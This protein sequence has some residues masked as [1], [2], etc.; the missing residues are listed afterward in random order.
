MD[1]SKALK[2]WKI[3]YI[4]IDLIVLLLLIFLS[5]MA[6]NHFGFYDSKEAQKENTLLIRM[7]DQPNKKSYGNEMRIKQIC[8]NGEPLN[9]QEYD[10][11]GWEWHENWGYTLFQEGDNEFSVSFSEIIKTMEVIYIR[12][13]GS[14][15][16]QFYWN[17]ELKQTVDMYSGKWSQGTFSVRYIS[18][19]DKFF[20]IISCWIVVSFILYELLRAFLFIKGTIPVEPINRGIGIYDFAKGVGIIFVVIGHT[21]QD[22]IYGREFAFYDPL[23]AII[24]LVDIYYILPMFYFIGGLNIKAS[25]NR[26]VIRKQLKTLLIPYGIYASMILTVNLVKLIFMD[27]FSISDYISY[28]MGLLLL[29]GHRKN[30]AGHFIMSIGPIWFIV[31]FCLGH[32]LVNYIINISNK[33]IRR[34]LM[35]IVVVTAY[36]LTKTDVAVLCVAE[37]FVAAI[38]LYIGHIYGKRIHNKLETGLTRSVYIFGLFASTLLVAFNGISFTLS[39]NNLGASFML[40][41]I[42][43]TLGGIAFLRELLD[44]GRCLGAKATVI[45]RIGR[46]SFFILFVHSFE[47]MIIPWNKF[48]QILPDYIYLRIFIVLVLRGVIIL[49]LS[50]FVLKI[51]RRCLRR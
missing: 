33:W 25:D 9:L 42:I 2:E 46:E 3:I 28:A 5:G 18:L 19:I 50:R 29:L 40:G 7:L 27:G 48:M 36:V 30:L 23:T 43:C 12:Q 14:G 26:R 11:Q 47:Y 39:G 15:R 8:I 4:I 17:G 45:K 13:E 1:N 6:F 24:G 16:C 49:V 34:L 35:I 22:Y 51:F 20:I 32:I 38:F 37:T 10:K 44:L 41:M 31:A 21:F